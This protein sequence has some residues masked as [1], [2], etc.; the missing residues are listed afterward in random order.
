MMNIDCLQKRKKVYLSRI[1]N[2]Q[3]NFQMETFA[4]KCFSLW[5]I[6][7]LRFIFL[8]KFS[9]KKTFCCMHF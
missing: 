7:E 4:L 8:Y 5:Q 9:N 6:Q 2:V 1:L 3:N